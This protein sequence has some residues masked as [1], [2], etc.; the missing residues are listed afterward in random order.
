MRKHPASFHED[1]APGI[2]AAEGPF[3]GPVWTGA[4]QANRGGGIGGLAGIISGVTTRIPLMDFCRGSGQTTL[5]PANEIGS[6][7]ALPDM[8]GVAAGVSPDPSRTFSNVLQRPQAPSFENV[9]ESASTADWVCR[10]STH[11]RPHA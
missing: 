2:Q 4:T 3:S 7:N 10:L 11:I 1:T 6:S 5:F 8:A 9:V